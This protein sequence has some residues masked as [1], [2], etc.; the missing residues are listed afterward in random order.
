MNYQLYRNTT[1]GNTLQET[2]DE[3]IVSGQ[4]SQ[5]LAQKVLLHFD[6]SINAA[7][8]ARVRSRLTFKAGHL[9]T[10]RYCDNVWTIVLKDAEFRETGELIQI[11]K[12]KIVACDGKNTQQQQQQTTKED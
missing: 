3:F 1:I 2:L 10:Y 5:Q 8:P 11:D 6:K 12:V 7:F 4:I 9:K